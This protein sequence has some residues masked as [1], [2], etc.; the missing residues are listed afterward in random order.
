MKPINLQAGKKAVKPLIAPAIALGL[1]AAMAAAPTTALNAAPSSMQDN[2][3]LMSVGGSKV[4]N[5][6]AKMSDVVI[7]DPNVVDVHVR[8]Q[9]QLYLIAKAAGET[10]VFATATNGLTHSGLDSPGGSTSNLIF[11]LVRKRG[12]NKGVFARYYSCPGLP[13]AIQRAW[14]AWSF[15]QTREVRVAWH[16]T[17][18]KTHRQISR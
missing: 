10:T 15:R 16:S 14:R 9:N 12:K 11:A 17:C 7:G 4:I 1:A 5:L 6:G 8:A 18:S 2:A 3:I 13:Q